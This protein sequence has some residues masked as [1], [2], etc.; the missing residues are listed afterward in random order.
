[1][2][3]RMLLAM[4]LALALALSACGA[5]PRQEVVRVDRASTVSFSESLPGTRIY[6]DGNMVG[7]TGAR[8]LLVTVADGTRQV[9]LVGPDGREAVMDIFIQDG[10]TRVVDT[11]AVLQK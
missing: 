11:R 4:P 7:I 10:T 8:P 2:I 6:V 1:M 9:R 3:G 5:M